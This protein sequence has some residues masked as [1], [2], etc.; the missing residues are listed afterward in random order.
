MAPLN[1]TDLYAPVKAYLENQGY[2]VKGEI[3]DCDLVAVRGAEDPVIVELKTAFNLNLVFQGIQR[4]TIS[5]NV[6]LAVPGP[7]RTARGL[8]RR[9]YWDIVRLCRLLG[10]GLIAVHPGRPQPMRI[11]VHLDPAPYRPRKSKV[12]RALLL[13]EFERRVGDPSPGGGNKRPIVTT[14][15]QDALR[16]AWY[17]GRNGSSKAAHIRVG[18]AVDLAPRILLRDVYGWFQRVERGIYELTPTGHAALDRYANVIT[19]ITDVGGRDT[20]VPISPAA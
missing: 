14:Y 8:W 16:C 7:G 11:E 10:L 18:A 3:E 12:R 9:H 1:E 4:K 20:P 15:R 2:A 13:G 6:Y 5:D 19:T 17:L